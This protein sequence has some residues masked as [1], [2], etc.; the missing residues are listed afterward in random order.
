MDNKK[1]ILDW[2]ETAKGKH[3]SEPT[4]KEKE[5]CLNIILEEVA[6]L[7]EAMGKEA[8]I[9]FSHLLDKKSKEI[10]NRIDKGDKL[11]DTRK[12][13]VD[14]LVDIEWVVTNTLY[15]YNILLEEY[16]KQFDTVTDSNYSKFCKTEEEA[17]QSCQ[18]YS[19]KGIETY[20]IGR[21]GLFII[22]RKEDNKI[23]KGIN[24]VEPA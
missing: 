12:D 15:F 16:Q 9:Y 21:N 6:E 3:E 22:L 7:S 1:R 4:K 8:F 23:L 18:A 2:L 14:A 17:K 19:D 20:Y 10:I 5:L 11:K 24:F 13:L